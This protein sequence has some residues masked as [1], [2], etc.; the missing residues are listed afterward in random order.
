M[1]KSV[2]N[3]TALVIFLVIF[4]RI[5]EYLIEHEVITL[6]SYWTPLQ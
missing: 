4:A 2:A 6:Q 5:L 1:L 3:A